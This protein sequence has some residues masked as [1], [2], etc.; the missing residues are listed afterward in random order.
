MTIT[1]DQ[2]TQFRALLKNEEK[3]AAT[4]NKYL[5]DIQRFALWL[6][7]TPLERDAMLD[8]KADLMR[9]YAAGSVNSILA[10]LNRFLRM[11]AREDCRVHRLRIQYQA[12]SPEE[13]EITA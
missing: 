8:Y 9:H 13:R 12:Y 10:A 5:R 4:L 6:G 7:D 2:L 3:S 1:T 11:I